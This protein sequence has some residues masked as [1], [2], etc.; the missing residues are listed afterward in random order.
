MFIFISGSWFVLERWIAESP[1]LQAKAPAQSDLDVALG[2]NAKEVLE[3]H[4]DTWITEQDFAW[5]ADR[6]L[7]AVRLPVSHNTIVVRTLVLM[8]S[9][10]GTI[11]FVVWTHRC[12]KERI[13]R[14]LATFSAVPGIES[15][16]QLSWRRD[17]GWGSSSVC[18]LNLRSVSSA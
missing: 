14:G 3:R 5:I 15:L 17:T 1:F 11:I 4:W 9:R 18:R 6:G 16:V 7:N 13:L 12:L 8:C 10:L 2:Q